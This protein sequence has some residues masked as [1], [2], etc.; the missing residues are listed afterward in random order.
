M[1]TWIAVYGWGPETDAPALVVYSTA[2]SEAKARE[3]ADTAA[4]K[5]GRENVCPGSDQEPQLWTVLRVPFG[6]LPPQADKTSAS[7]D[8]VERG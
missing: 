8:V 1:T 2:T 7:L 6:Q 4:E 5:Y 3:L